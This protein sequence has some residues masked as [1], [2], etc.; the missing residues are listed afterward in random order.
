VTSTNETFLFSQSVT[1]SA[2]AS[3]TFYVVGNSNL[4]GIFNLDYY[5]PDIAQARFL[6]ASPNVGAVDFLAN[7]T[8]RFP[9]V[10]FAGASSY[11]TFAEGHYDYKIVPNG[12]FDPVI[13]NG[14]FS[15]VKENVYTNVLVGLNANNVN[16]TS[17]LALLHLVDDNSLP[18]AGKIKVRFIHASP[19]TPN[20]DISTNGVH[21]FNNVSYKSATTYGLL[22]ADIYNVEIL[23]TGQTATLFSVSVDMRVVE[24]SAVYTLVA[25]GIRGGTPEL[26]VV[27]YLD[28][29]S[30]PPPPSG[31]SSPKKP[32]LAAWAIALIVIAVLLVVVLVAAGGFVWY[33][34]RSQR[35]EYAEISAP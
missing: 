26:K 17:T 32:G 19:N 21:L 25:E 30:S 18:V 22:N 3:Y 11:L 29:G 8:L 2:G 31:K 14:S 7:G 34:K 33:R 5:P 4:T 20:L 12:A 35:A 16:E 13:T 15:L 9:N 10:S 24:G 28:N 6:H 1:A 23:L 27:S